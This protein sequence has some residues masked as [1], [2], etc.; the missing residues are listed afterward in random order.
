V[1][2]ARSESFAA[3]LGGLSMEM[4]H[5]KLDV[6][7]LAADVARWV[8]Q[9]PFPRGLSDLKN[10]GNRAACSVALNIAEGL[11]RTNKAR[12]NHLQIARGSAAEVLTVLD[13]AGPKEA[14]QQME[15]LRRI[16][17]MLQKMGG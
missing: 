1:K 17:R 10:K 4:Y 14:S 15:R 3:L 11:K 7:R 13:I 2:A 5:E 12:S 6:Y 16:D 9:T 8:I